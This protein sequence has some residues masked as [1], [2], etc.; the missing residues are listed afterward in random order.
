MNLLANNYASSSGT[1]DTIGT[2]RY[3]ERRRNTKL[4]TLRDSELA[5]SD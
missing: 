4:S 3:P 5:K 1:I 2:Q